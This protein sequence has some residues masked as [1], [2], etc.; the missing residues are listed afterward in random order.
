EPVTVVALDYGFSSSSVFSRAF[1]NYFGMSATE[2]R[3]RGGRKDCKTVRKNGQAAAGESEYDT[4][5]ECDVMQ[6][7]IPAKRRTP[8]KVFE[9]VP[10]E[11]RSQETLHVAY[12]RH[13]GPYAGDSRLFEG[14]FARL[15]RWAGPRGL[16]A[17][18]DLQTLIVYHDNPDL[19]DASR[20]R[21]SVCITVPG[22]TAVS[23][24]V[25]AMEIPVGQYACA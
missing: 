14:L 22:D 3:R 10:V 21:T 13:V 12:V 15:M 11:I 1:R 8:M 5:V 20:L 7:F 24:E 17:R 25:G 16:L 6:S 4:G 18:P 2:W 19:T 23:G 9:N